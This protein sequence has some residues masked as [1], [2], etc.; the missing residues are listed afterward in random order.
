MPSKG[1][2]NRKRLRKGARLPY[3]ERATIDPQKLKDYALDPDNP[4]KSSGFAKLDI[5][6]KDWR[7][8]HDE[9]LASL[10][11][12]EALYGDI[13]I[14]HRRGFEVHSA[15][16]GLNGREAV[17]VTGWWIDSRCEPWLATCYARPKRS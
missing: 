15:V 16:R 1:T 7:Y 2:R 12:A 6:R 14:P 5:F 11:D 10:P 13:S 4:A 3:Y 9:I 17:V 8:L